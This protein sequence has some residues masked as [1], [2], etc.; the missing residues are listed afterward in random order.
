MA[1][2]QGHI[3]VVYEDVLNERYGKVSCGAPALLTRLQS[4]LFGKD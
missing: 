1:D 3:A 2:W 4:W